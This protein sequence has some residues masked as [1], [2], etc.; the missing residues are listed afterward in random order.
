MQYRTFTFT[1]LLVYYFAKF[2]DNN[3]SSVSSAFRNSTIDALK[4][5]TLHFIRF[6]AL[7]ASISTSYAV[8]VSLR[9]G[10]IPDPARSEDWREVQVARDKAPGGP[11]YAR[12]LWK[13][14][15]ST[16]ERVTCRGAN[17]TRSRRDR[18][19]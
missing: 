12:N 4:K 18:D 7:L 13:H 1:C 9:P 17:R 14:D 10:A 19:G 5:A 16:H 11:A 6:S 3:S 2:D 15:A 8:N